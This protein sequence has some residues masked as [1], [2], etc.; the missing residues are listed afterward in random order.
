M[1][2]VE[3]GCPRVLAWVPDRCIPVLT[4]GTMNLRL[5]G[6]GDKMGKLRLNDWLQSQVEVATI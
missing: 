6:L 3:M 1:G 2:G 4:Q 5:G